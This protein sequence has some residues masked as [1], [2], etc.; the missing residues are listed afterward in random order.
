MEE[1]EG[2]SGV[3]V[4]RYLEMKDRGRIHKE[5]KEMVTESVS[6][7]DYLLRCVTIQGLRQSAVIMAP[8]STSQVGDSSARGWAPS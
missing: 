7:T 4:P 3:D 1:R 8:Q 5:V 6:I 2:E